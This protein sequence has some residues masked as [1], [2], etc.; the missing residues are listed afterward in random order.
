MVE[1]SLRV[2]LALAGLSALTAC[3]GAAADSDTAAGAQYGHVHAMAV[4][5]GT[6][7]LAT[8]H[9]LF[10]VTRDGAPT[11]VGTEDHDFMGFAALPDGT[12]LGSG[13]P[14][15][16]KDLPS[17]LGLLQSTDRG[18]TWQ[19]RSLAGEADFHALAASGSTTYGWNSVSGRLMS[20]RD[21]TTWR[22]VGDARIAD[23]AVHPTS[24]GTVLLA[25]EN[26]PARSTD[27]GATFAA[28]PNAPLLLAFA[29]P[30][31]KVLYGLGVDGDV[32]RSVDAGATW[33]PA[34]KVA[35]APGEIAVGPDGAVY[36]ADDSQILVST[37]GAA[38]F[39]RFASLAAQG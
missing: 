39:T 4:L 28:V 33:E 5:D 22:T 7:H 1:R 6:L 18:L 16:R 3:G 2:L 19:T 17:H 9:G 13:H 25:T 30:S 21:R 31:A 23:I 36:L 26:G 20:S 11:R 35:S 32:H 14:N 29:W 10:R 38:T 37:D 15:S 12:L 34:G 8:H 24:P 27:E